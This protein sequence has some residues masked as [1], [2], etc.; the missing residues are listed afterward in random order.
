MVYQNFCLR[1]KSV[2]P[3]NPIAALQRSFRQ[4]TSRLLCFRGLRAAGMDS[5]FLKQVAFAES[6]MPGCIRLLQTESYLCLLKCLG[7]IDQC[8]QS[9]APIDMADAID[10]LRRTTFRAFAG[11]FL[12]LERV[13]TGPMNIGFARSKLVSLESTAN[14]PPTSVAA[15]FPVS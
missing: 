2:R 5:W 14:R 3:I 6:S 15:L 13:K 7:R 10:C 12:K 8:D 11:S 4:Q 1:K 9:Y